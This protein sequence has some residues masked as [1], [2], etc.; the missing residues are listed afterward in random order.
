[1]LPLMY[2]LSLFLLW[3]GWDIG[4]KRRYLGKR[5]VRRLL[6]EA[7]PVAAILAAMAPFWPSWL[8]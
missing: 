7:L 2:P 6:L 3:C 1:M 8:M 4:K 5:G